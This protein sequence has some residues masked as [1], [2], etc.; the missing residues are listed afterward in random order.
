MIPKPKLP[1]L[2][3]WRDRHGKTRSAYRRADATDGKR[4]EYPL[5]GPIG[6]ADWHKA[7]TEIHDCYEREPPPPPDQKAQ[8][9]FTLENIL[10]VATEIPQCG[11]YFLVR[12]NRVVYVGKS[13]NLL[14]RLGQH[15]HDQDFDRIAFIECEECDL[16]S[17]EKAYITALLPQLNN[18]AVAKSAR[19]RL[20]R[21]NILR[22]LQIKAS[23]RK[24]QGDGA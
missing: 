15:S 7:Y 17:L 23:A 24:A 2:K 19:K 14:G 9:T 22:R 16:N 11:I 20:D 3:V 5:P 8:P 18:C 12:N 6:S 10:A 4:H 1:Y 13:T 21:S